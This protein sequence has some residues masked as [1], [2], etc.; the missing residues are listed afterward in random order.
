MRLKPDSLAGYRWLI[1]IRYNL[2]S[3][4]RV[5]LMA[6]RIRGIP[7]YYAGDRL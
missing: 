5:N 7:P 2:P 3:T 1:D 6:S 4:I